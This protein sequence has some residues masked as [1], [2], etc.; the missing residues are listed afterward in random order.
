MQL[1]SILKTAQ[2][3]YFHDQNAVEIAINKPPSTKLTAFFKLWE[4]DHFVS[5]L[6]IPDVPRF[7]RRNSSKK[8]AKPAQTS[9]ESLRREYL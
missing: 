8:D 6:L 4:G 9:E 7:Y 1:A 3:L 5:N 2:R